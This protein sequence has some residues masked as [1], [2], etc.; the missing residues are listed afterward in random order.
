MSITL[1]VPSKIVHE[2]RIYAERNATSINQM[3]RD[4]LAEVVGAETSE[5]SLAAEF[6]QLVER[7]GVKRAKPYR[8]H[9]ADAY[10]EEV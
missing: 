4:Y 2:A 6:A 8:F 5:Q 7:R 10:E 3:I 9:R 1:S